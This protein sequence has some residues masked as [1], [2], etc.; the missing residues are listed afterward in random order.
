HRG[1]GG[2][3]K[4]VND[5]IGGD[6]YI[7]MKYENQSTII[8]GWIRV[9]CKSADSCFVKDY[10]FNTNSFGTMKQKEN[11]VSVFPN[12]FQQAFLIEGNKAITELKIIDIFGQDIGFTTTQADHRTKI[13]LEN[14]PPGCYIIKCRVNDETYARKI[15]KTNN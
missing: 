9:Q 4:N 10:S 8:Y 5:W 1:W 12:P 6:K 15:I 13:D 11:A 3:K 2:L 7:G 14:N